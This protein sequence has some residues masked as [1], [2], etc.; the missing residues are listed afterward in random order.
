MLAVDGLDELTGHD[1]N[2]SLILDYLPR[3]D[4]LPDGCY[5]LLTSRPE[6]R[7]PVL[8]SLAGRLGLASADDDHVPDVS[9][10][11][12]ETGLEGRKQVERNS[13]RSE[14]SES[15]SEHSELPA[16]RNEFRS[17]TCTATSLDALGAAATYRHVACGITPEYRDLLRTF[18][19]A[20]FGESVR[21]HLDAILKRG[22]E[23]FLYVRFL[24]DLLRL[25]MQEQGE[26]VLTDLCPGDLPA[27]DDVFPAYLE[28]LSRAVAARHGDPGLF[29]AW[30]RPV[31]LLIAAAYEPVTC[32]H[33]RCW[34]GP[35]D[36]DEWANHYLNCALDDLAALLSIER[37][38]DLPGDSRCAPAHRE[39]VQWLERN[40]HPDW[41]TALAEQGHRRIL[42][43]AQKNPLPPEAAQ[44][45]PIDV[46]HLLHTPSHWL[47]VGDKEVAW[48]CLLD[49]HA[50]GLLDSLTGLYCNRWQW[51][52]EVAV[53][54]CRI[55]QLEGLLP[56]ESSSAIT[57]PAHILEVSYLALACMNRGVARLAQMDFPGAVADFDRAIGLL[58]K[59]LAAF[60]EEHAAVADQLELVNNLAK[61]YGN[62]GLAREDQQDF[63]AAVADLDRA[64]ELLEIL[65]AVFGGE[66]AAVADQP[67]LVNDL[68]ATYTNRG[69]A[70]LAQQDFA[71]AV[72]DYDRAI[73]LLEKL[74]AA[75]GGEYAAVAAQPAL[76]NGLA[77]AYGN[78]GGARQDQRSLTAAVADCDRAIGLREKLLA[79]FGGEDAAV[80]AQPPLVN[81]LATAYMN[82]GVARDD[83]QDFAAAV[84]DYD[85]AI[86][87]LEKLLAAF[88]GEDAAVAAQP[89]L[90][91]DL[92]AAYSNRGFARRCHEDFAA[93]V[94]DYDRAIGLGKNCWRPSAARTRRW[95]PNR[96]WSRI[97]AT[98]TCAG[99]SGAKVSRISP[100]RRRTTT[101]PSG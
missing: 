22:R 53:W 76:V 35:R 80:A 45:T 61:A 32:E 19:L 70:R 58:E 100:R 31:L 43:A 98:R 85:R 13:F 23:R 30:H 82:R 52:Q 36:W 78:R 93:A 64:I 24:R 62:R 33:L 59:L 51:A 44:C 11:E 49:L 10:R 91:N 65:L 66:D 4:E 21:P 3:A 17:T 47:A 63:A 90:V 69:V 71:A 2:R 67:E 83:Q 1:T 57:S 73:G 28:W 25:R 95:R 6:L 96:D 74:L 77:N 99:A 5:I 27:G 18:L 40:T 79:A 7:P 94:A 34:L 60:G 39:F 48:E 16:E 46:Y 84:A 9:P 29:A 54:N 92:A 38:A 75:F 26:R 81:D 89:E 86:G 56:D 12:F 41:Q 87:L 42:A 15:R 97:W 88:G 101:G 14:P 72:A 8:R 50:V 55:E 68:G 20:S 37:P